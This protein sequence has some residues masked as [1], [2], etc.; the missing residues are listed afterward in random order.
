MNGASFRVAIYARGKDPAGLD[1]Q[2]MR[3]INYCDS[4]GYEY[5]VFREDRPGSQ[6]LNWLLRRMLMGDF[7]MC[8]VTSVDRL[9]RNA[10]VAERLM[11]AMGRIGRLDVVEEESQDGK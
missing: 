3:C 11:L 1:R 7:Q 4:R 5:V 10:T 9:D 6:E 2:V 8:V